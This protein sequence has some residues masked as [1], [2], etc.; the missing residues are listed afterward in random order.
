MCFV[1]TKSF[2]LT[3][4]L[5][6]FLMGMRYYFSRKVILHYLDCALHTDMSDIE[7][8]Y[9]KPPGEYEFPEGAFLS[10]PAG[11]HGCSLLLAPFP[12]VSSTE[13][14]QKSPECSSLATPGKKPSLAL[15]WF[16][17]FFADFGFFNFFFH[18]SPSTKCLVIPGRLCPPLERCAAGPT[19][20]PRAGLRCLGTLRLE[21]V[22]LED[23]G[24][25]LQPGPTPALTSSAWWVFCS[26]YLVLALTVAGEGDEK[27]FS[28]NAQRSPF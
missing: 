26:M 9:M 23:V 17:V 22:I 25:S 13:Q 3:C 14:A 15:V 7:Q 6:I 5:P 28:P 8:Y 19:A 16:G 21:D 11:E 4:C 1:V 20:T 12:P 24:Y 2:L 18:Y 27:P 10:Q